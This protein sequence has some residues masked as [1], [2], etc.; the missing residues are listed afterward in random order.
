M[1][2]D[3]I[4]MKMDEYIFG[5]PTLTLPA[6]SYVF[7]IQNLGFEGHN[8][9]ILRG[10]TLITKLEDDLSPARMAFLEVTFEPGEYVLVC[11]IAGHDGKGMVETM[12]I[13]PADP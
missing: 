2:G 8:L 11:T 5:L 6:G 7:H 1:R 13:V 10:D 3:T 4:E 12:T 9:E